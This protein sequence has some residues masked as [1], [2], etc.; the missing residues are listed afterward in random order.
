LSSAAP[1]DAPKVSRYDASTR[2]DVTA[3]QNAGH[4]IV[5][6]FRNAADS[7]ISTMNP[8][9]SSV[10]PSARSKPGSTLCRFSS[11]REKTMAL[12]DFFAA[13]EDL[14]VDRAVVEVLLLRLAPAA[15]HSSMVKVDL[16]EVL[17]VLRSSA[18]RARPQLVL[19]ANLLRL[20][21]PQV[22]EI[23][24]GLLAR[25]LLVDHLVDHRD[26]FSARMLTG[27]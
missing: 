27:G 11:A 2:G 17:R 21:G 3:S 18:G 5:N 1:N 13:F 4:V 24:L 22:L 16:R 19:A 10:K 6:V 15:E 9:Y 26:G 8:R 25:A 23:G 14:V 12:T 7:G 20:V